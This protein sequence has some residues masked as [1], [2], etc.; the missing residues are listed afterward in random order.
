MIGHY[1]DDGAVV[2]DDEMP[3]M[4]NLYGDD[5]GMNVTGCNGGDG[6][7]VAVVVAAI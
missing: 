3:M 1:C 6:E 5:A 2:G 4:R 7:M